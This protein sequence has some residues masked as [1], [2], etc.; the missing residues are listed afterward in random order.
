MKAGD[1]AKIKAST[2]DQ[3]VTVTRVFWRAAA[4]SGVSYIDSVEVMYE[5]GMK[6]NVPPKSIEIIKE[7]D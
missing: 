6:A 5:N 1:R 4:G 7:V 2:G 3:T